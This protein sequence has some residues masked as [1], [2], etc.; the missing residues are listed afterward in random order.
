MTTTPALAH[1]Y[2]MENPDEGARLE[3]KTEDATSDRLLA[4]TDLRPGMRALDA[5]AG[6]GAVA[7]RMSRIVGASGS[8]V[9]LDRSLDRLQQGRNSAAGPDFDNL[10]FATGDLECDDDLP[11]GPY[12]Y[13][14]CRFVFEYL[15]DPDAALDRLTRAAR[16]GGKIVVADLD[17]NAAF[18]HPMSKE[19][20]AGLTRV[21]AAL[22]PSFDPYAG[23]KLYDRFRRR[24]LSDVRVHVEPYH[25][26]AGAASAAALANWAQK[27]RTIRPAALR[28]FESE[29]AYDLWAAEFLEMLRSPDAFSYSVLIVVEG[30]RAH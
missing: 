26:Y 9:A 11:H 19:L 2:L 14:F 21:F 7:R 5:G 27:L 8:V 12:D 3:A 24:G 28:A 20:E 1:P 30:I 10:R 18:H 25:V 23:R 29:R 17:G 13:V 22:A 16:I 6:T 15:R 4:L